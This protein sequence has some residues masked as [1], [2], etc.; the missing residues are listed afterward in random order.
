MEYEHIQNDQQLADFCASLAGATSIA[1]DT[2]FVSE[3][4][5]RPELCLIQVAANG[6][7]AVIDPLAI[8]DVTPFWRLLTNAGHETIVHAGREEFRF[9]LYATE[10]RPSGWFDIQMAA[11]FVGLEY[12]AAYSTLISKLL[13]KNLPKGE[14]RTDW[15]RRPLSK[16]QIEY[17][18]QDVMYLK[19]LRDLLMKQVDELDRA[20]WLVEE[21]DNWQAQLELTENTEQWRRV[22][23][24]AGLN[25]RQLAIVRELWRWRDAEAEKRDRPPKRILRDDLIVEVARRQ[26]DQINRIRAVRGMDHRH[27][28]KVLPEIAACVERGLNLP[29]A[30]CPKRTRRKDATQPPFVLLGQ[31][32]NAALGCI[33]RSNQLA[34]GLVGSVQDVRDLVA[35]RLGLS[36]KHAANAP[37]LAQGWRA[38]V[39]GKQIDQLLAGETVLRIA[40]PTADLPLDLAP[41]IAAES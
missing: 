20:A 9:C 30:E 23:G 5:Y 35:Y 17:A 39:V 2:E 24:S 21:L 18:L 36:N 41:Y 10:S 29:D 16:K 12:P 15:R 14:T 38:E 11:G 28:Q 6:C 34:P 13:S 26:T 8:T 1:F 19:P 25:S 3:D 40:D 32:L 4:T 22:S 27:V 31:F 33:C 7:L 37:S